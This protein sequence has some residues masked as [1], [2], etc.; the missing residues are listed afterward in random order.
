MNYQDAINKV[1]LHEGGFVN[2]PNDRGGPTNFG[3]TQKVYE[4]FKGRKVSVEEIRN[5][6]K[7]DAVAIYKKNYW[8][9][10]G[11]D[12]IKFYSVAFAIF[13]QS[14]NRGVSAAVKQAQRILGVQADGKAGT[15]TL[16]MINAASELDFLN[17]YLAASENAYRSIAQN[18]GQDG[19]LKGWLNRLSSLSKYTAENLGKPNAATAGGLALVLLVGAYLILNSKKGVV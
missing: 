6:P 17:K 1:L 19:F 9:Q 7:A 18:P 15:G 14:V 3:I 12:K 5:M 16:A 4:A 13:D 8:D 2:N 11:G 10:V